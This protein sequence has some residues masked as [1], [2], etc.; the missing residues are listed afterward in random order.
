M[1][2]SAFTPGKLN[3]IFRKKNAKR[4]IDKIPVEYTDSHPYTHTGTQKLAR[5][6]YKAEESL[7]ARE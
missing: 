2:R 3:L 1:P 5:L 4:N 6:A 7:R